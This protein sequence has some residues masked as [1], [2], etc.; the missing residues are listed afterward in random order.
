M[1]L[2]K[3]EKLSQAANTYKAILN[4]ME[5][6]VVIVDHQSKIFFINRPYARF[7]GVKAEDVKGKKVT[8]V[9]ENTRMHITVQTGQAERFSFQKIL[10]SKMIASRL[11]I[12]DQ[13]EVIG[14]VGTVIFHDTHEWKQ[15]NSH[16]KALLAEQ[17]F[18]YQKSI[19]SDKLNTG[20]N[21]HL[22][23][24]I[25]DSQVM[26]SLSAKVT[27]VASGDVTV[28]IRG[29]SGTGKEL[30]AHAIHQLS[31]RAEYPFIKV[32]CAA[33]PESLLESELFG[34]EEGAFTGA[35]KGGKPGKFQLANGGT[36]FLDEIGDLPLLMQAKLLR[37]LQD[38]EVESVGGTQPMP[39]NIRLITATHRPLESLIESG[40]FRGDLYYRIN[41]VAIDLPPL[42]ERRGDIAKLADFF[43]QKLSR[44]TGRR[45]PKLTVQALTAM[46]AYNW[47]GN[48]RELENVIEAAFYTS[49][50]RKIPLSLLPAQLSQTDHSTPKNQTSKGIIQSTG[51]LKEQL[52]L[53]EK[54]IINAALIECGDN[55]TKAAKKLG[56][57]KSTFYE[58]LDKHGI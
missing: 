31:D 28:L 47:P 58:K 11:P 39:L 50:D 54:N 48:I 4:A 29:E 6:W 13:G 7:L 22:N 43:L 8:D 35:K 40:A 23:D 27:Q 17:D 21:F 16:I 32:N 9:I 37:V 1:S 42:R 52:N 15:I 36:L 26:K 30:Y 44:R 20:A 25:G 57:S 10:G 46:I 18:Q 34:Y 49:H 45:A 33:I 12:V 55:R 24:I 5:E 14:A 3:L 51:S 19:A 38:R 41:V 2:K 56:I 53:A